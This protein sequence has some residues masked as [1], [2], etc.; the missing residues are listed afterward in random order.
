MGGHEQPSTAMGMLTTI[1]F[2]NDCF[3]EIKKDPE[4]YM[5]LILDAMQGQEVND[6]AMIAQRPVHSHDMAV[7]VCAGN[8]TTDVSHPKGDKLNSLLLHVPGFFATL[9]VAV[10]GCGKGLADKWARR[11]E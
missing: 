2:R 1:T 3:H 11:N 7:Y 4:R 10:Q 8:T 9:M 6:G 5:E